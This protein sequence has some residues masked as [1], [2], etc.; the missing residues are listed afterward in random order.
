M[1]KSVFLI[2]SVVWTAI[3]AA[4]LIILVAALSGANLT[5]NLPDWLR[6]GAASNAFGDNTT[7][8]KEER[9]NLSGI[10]EL[11]VDVRYQDIR[12]ALIDGGDMVVRH[13][14]IE[15]AEAFKPDN[16]GS[17]L[18][19]KIPE[20]NFTFFNISN[21][22]LEIDL[23]RSYADSVMLKSSSGDINLDGRAEWGEASIIAS[24]GD[25]RLG[26]GLTCEN[27]SVGTSSG[28][29]TLG[30]VDAGAIQISS[31]SGSQ[32]LNELRALGDVSLKS[33]SGSINCG[34]IAAL[35]L[36]INNASG[37]LRIGD[38]NAGGR[39]DITTSS[40]S[41][42]AGNIRAASYN[43]STASGALRYGGLSGAGSV[44]ASSGSI[45]CDALDVKGDVSLTSTSGDQRLTL[46]PDQSFDLNITSASGTIRA[47]G[48]ELYYSDRNGKNAFATVGG[49]NG[50]KL[51]IRSSSGSV[52]I[53]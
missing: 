37:D 12:I 6:G 16:N 43:I 48:F 31:A 50:G 36:K 15:Q 30:N 7:L 51:G 38:A 46:A 24:S 42:H 35:N 47:S 33:S 40:G 11:G 52:S 29:I 45:N 44:S 18:N 53:N 19:I 17:R 28:S 34:D 2:G 20:V 1:K 32:R 10:K 14:D 22:R 23:P 21:A 9:Y 5:K 39:V 13:Y 3:A 41:H 49:E 27:L 25:V 4:A 8:K 26:E